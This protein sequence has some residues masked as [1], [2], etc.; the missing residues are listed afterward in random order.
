MSDAI[1]IF[2]SP[3][4]TDKR[5]GINVSSDPATT[6]ALYVNGDTAITGDISAVGDAII[7]GE[8]K[9]EGIYDVWTSKDNTQSLGTTSN[10]VKFQNG[11]MIQWGQNDIQ[12]VTIKVCLD[13]QLLI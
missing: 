13:T 12:S 1:K 10:Y 4:D 2:S 5:V 8:I 3:S 9:A 6:D 11:L 7:S